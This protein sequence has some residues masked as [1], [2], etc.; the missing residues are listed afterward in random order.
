[1]RPKFRL[2]WTVRGFAYCKGKTS[3]EMIYDTNGG[4]VICDIPLKPEST[5]DKRKKNAED[6]AK[7]VASVS[8]RAMNAAISRVELEFEEAK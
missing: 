4:W 6:F 7:R 1:M 2:R 3:L 8:S 5:L